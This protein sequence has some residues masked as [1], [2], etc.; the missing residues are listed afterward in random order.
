VSSMDNARL[1]A[2][3]PAERRRDD[4]A[5]RSQVIRQLTLLVGAGLVVA[6]G[7][8]PAAAAGWSIQPVPLPAHSGDSSLSG[9]SC[10]SSNACI[11]VGS[12]AWN[13]PLAER[14][15]RVS[16]GMDANAAWER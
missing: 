4:R 10:T 11:A 9:V 2:S 3:K 6:A 12:S 7:A 15:N 16:I 1:R 5:R 8:Q 13:G 14:W